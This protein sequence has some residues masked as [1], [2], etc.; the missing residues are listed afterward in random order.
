MQKARLS[1]SPAATTF[2]PKASESNSSR[3]T[4]PEDT[5]LNS[6]RLSGS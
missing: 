5:R 2:D 4:V 1:L 6:S 3:N